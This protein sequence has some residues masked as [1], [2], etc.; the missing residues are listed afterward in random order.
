MKSN[1]LYVLA[2]SDRECVQFVGG[3]EFYGYALID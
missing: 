1:P 3:L 2:L